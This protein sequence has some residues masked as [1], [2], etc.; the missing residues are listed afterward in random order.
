[1]RLPVWCARVGLSLPRRLVD[2]GG[3]AVAAA[4]QAGA[5]FVAVPLLT[6]LLGPSE[7]GLWVIFEPLAAAMAQVG[8]LGTNHG[9]LKLVGEDNF[10][11]STAWRALIGPVL[12]PLAAMAA[13]AFAACSLAGQTAAAPVLSLLVMLEGITLLC[14]AAFRAN[15]RSVFFAC[16]LMIK[17]ALWLLVLWAAQSLGAPNLN[18]ASQALMWLLVPSAGACLLALMLLWCSWPPSAPES[19]SAKPLGSFMSSVRYGLPLMLAGLLATA[20]AVGDRY[21]ML[22]LADIATIGQYVVLVKVASAIS[23]LGMPINMWFP[24]AR[25]THLH[26]DDGGGRFFRRAAWVVVLGMSACAGALWLLTPSLVA[27]FNPAQ[28]ADVVAVAC[29]LTGAVATASSGLMNVALLKSG[30]THWPLV[31]TAIAGGL[32][33]LALLVLVPLAGV[34]GAAVATGAAGLLGLLM[35]LALSQRWQKLPFAFALM[36]GQ[37]LLVVAA[38][39]SIHVLLTD[40]VMQVASF[41]LAMLA[42]AWASLAI[43]SRRRVRAAPEL[44]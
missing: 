20:V 3:Y 11:W 22:G 25:F 15:N 10:A 41:G 33:L 29:L 19:L 43:E 13:V 26:D 24:A 38:C 2:L 21:V 6:R 28:T 23:L 14:L 42:L 12:A 40:P 7:F 39:W 37:V 44:P 5:A 36:L 27:W 30:R 35:Q 18:L 17:A 31:C 4:A 16:I 34:R 1:M 9:L 8:L 32:Q